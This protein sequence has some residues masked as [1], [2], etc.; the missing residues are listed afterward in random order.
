MFSS[1]DLNIV[2]QWIAKR[3]PKNKPEYKSS[4]LNSLL[5]NT[6]IK[7][8]KAPRNVRMPTRDIEL[9]SEVLIIKGIDPQ[10]IAKK[11][12]KR[13]ALSFV[14]KLIAGLAWRNC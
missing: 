14:F 10:Q 9:T 5:R 11:L 2:D 7:R 4:L 8:N 1:I 13:Y 3:G 12:I 6:K